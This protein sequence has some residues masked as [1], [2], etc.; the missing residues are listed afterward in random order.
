MRKAEATRSG[1]GCGLSAA[2]QGF[3]VTMESPYKD[4]R[5]KG[6][7]PGK[8]NKAALGTGRAQARHNALQTSASQVIQPGFNHNVAEFFGVTQK[9]DKKPRRQPI[10][11][12]KIVVKDATWKL[13]QGYVEENAYEHASLPAIPAGKLVPRDPSLRLA[14]GSDIRAD[15][16]AGIPPD[17]QR[18]PP[19]AITAPVA[20][21][22][23]G[24]II[25]KDQKWSLGLGYEATAPRASQ[26]DLQAQLTAG[27]KIAKEAPWKPTDG[28]TR[29]M[30]SRSTREDKSAAL[31]PAGK[32]IPKGQPLSIAAGKPESLES[33]RKN[34]EYVAFTPELRS[35]RL[36]ENSNFHQTAGKKI[37]RDPAF[38]LAPTAEKPTNASFSAA[39]RAFFG[40]SQASAL[41][42]QTPQPYRM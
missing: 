25:P 40:A 22:P 29:E 2:I 37:P 1:E 19:E 8:S 33:Y 28:F 41:R 10:P 30:F 39:E 18:I 34:R 9:E 32:L 14:Y 42:S 13:S 6:H 7:S 38:A 12:G 27:V 26:L 4:Q 31:G 24:K 11:A 23:A 3:T 15:E 5:L 21:I 16:D 35:S 17:P 36:V 20:S